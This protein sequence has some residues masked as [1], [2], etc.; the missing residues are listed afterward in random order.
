MF[1]GGYFSSLSNHGNQ[2][3][4]CNLVCL[5]GDVSA[6]GMP[7]LHEGRGKENHDSYKK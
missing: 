7:L 3:E 4:I 1:K 2:Y 6:S 5:L